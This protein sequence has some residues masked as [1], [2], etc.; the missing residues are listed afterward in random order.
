MDYRINS[1]V[2]RYYKQVLLILAKLPPFDQLD[3]RE[4]ELLSTIMTKVYYMRVHMS[5]T[6]E[7]DRSVS[8]ILD[9]EIW[10]SIRQ[11]LGMTAG[12]MYK[13][14][15]TL[16]KKGFL[17]GRHQLA[18]HVDLP[19][20]Q[21]ITFRFKPIESTERVVTGNETKSESVKTVH[22]G[23]QPGTARVQRAAPA[24]PA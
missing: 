1:N 5:K 13:N 18:R 12:S 3:N 9:K 23:K 2:Q 14:L 15:S 22:Q 10:A 20:F 24:V 17:T 7:E 6:G 21:D 4:R 16:K 11:E 8:I 19:M